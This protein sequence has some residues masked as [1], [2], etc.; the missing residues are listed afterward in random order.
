MRAN[1]MC[2]GLSRERRAVGRP[3]SKWCILS[4]FRN[5]SRKQDLKYRDLARPMPAISIPYRLFDRPN[6]EA[7]H[8]VTLY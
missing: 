4:P 7:A 6:G 2:E 8:D 5:R 3:S 1:G